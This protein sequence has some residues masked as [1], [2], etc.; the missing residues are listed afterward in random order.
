MAEPLVSTCS[1]ILGV[2]SI[3]IIVLKPSGTGDLDHESRSAA[4][5]KHVGGA[6]RFL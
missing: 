6:N 3:P 5:I 4:D 1:I 2:M